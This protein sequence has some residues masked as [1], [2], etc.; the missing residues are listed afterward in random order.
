MIDPGCEL[1][2]CHENKAA[3]P[4]LHVMRS[5]VSCG[6][7]IA[8]NQ[9]L[10][11]TQEQYICNYRVLNLRTCISH[12]SLHSQTPVPEL[13]EN[14]RQIERTFRQNVLK[15][16]LFN[17]IRKSRIDN[18]SH[19][20]FVQNDF[21]SKS[22]LLAIIK[23]ENLINTKPSCLLKIV[24]SGERLEL[25]ECDF[26]YQTNKYHTIDS[27]G[28][29]YLHITKFAISELNDIIY[30]GLVVINYTVEPNEFKRW[31]SPPVF[32]YFI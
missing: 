3:H 11:L 15:V 23:L 2:R 20:C 14:H 29:A 31:R 28:I 6:F 8:I 16:H 30:L 13:V 25:N 10:H 26:R 17:S 4:I 19:E 21:W 32:R 27:N 18:H 1:V 7:Q 22:F 24:I 12:L 9:V 5:Y